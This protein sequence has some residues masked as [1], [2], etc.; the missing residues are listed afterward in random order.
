MMARSAALSDSQ[1]RN[2]EF[3]A[4]EIGRMKDTGGYTPIKKMRNEPK[5]LFRIN[6]TFWNEPE[7]CA[8]FD[9]IR[10]QEVL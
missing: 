6:K 4:T 2:T 8:I 7:I 3:Q 1:A 9:E 10:T 5:K